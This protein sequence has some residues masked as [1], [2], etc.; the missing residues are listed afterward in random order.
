MTSKKKAARKTQS[1]A[2]R[3]NAA[4]T[5]NTTVSAASTAASSGARVVE[6][7]TRVKHNGECF[8]AGA[9]AEFPVE[10]A[11]R[12]IAASEAREP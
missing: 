9:L 10:V 7:L 6:L 3:G 2:A 8:E 12:L 11:D 4:E 1:E 5:V